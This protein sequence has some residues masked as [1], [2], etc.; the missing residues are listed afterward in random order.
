MMA[1]CTEEQVSRQT[2]SRDYWQRELAA[3]RKR[4]EVEE[5]DKRRAL[6]RVEELQQELRIV[7]RQLDQFQGRQM[8]EIASRRRAALQYYRDE[9]ARTHPNYSGGRVVGRGGL[10][11]PDADDSGD[12]CDTVD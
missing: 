4:L 6:A 3:C 10:I 12:G 11:Q 2:A 7:H 9:Y 8:A 5:A 1:H